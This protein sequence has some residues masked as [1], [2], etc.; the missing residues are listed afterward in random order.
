MQ[1]KLVDPWVEK[2]PWRREWQC[3][4]L[5]S[6]ILAWRITWTEEPGEI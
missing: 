3:T 2:F 4:L 5:C 1:E 6:N